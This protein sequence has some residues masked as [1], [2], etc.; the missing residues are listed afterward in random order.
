MTGRNTI[1]DERKGLL[2]RYTQLLANNEA[3]LDKK[4]QGKHKKNL[5]NGYFSTDTSSLQAELSNHRKAVLLIRF[6][7]EIFLRWDK[8]CVYN[9][10]DR[11]V[12]EKIKLYDIYDKYVIFPIELDKT[13][14][15]WF[16]AHLLYDEGMKSYDQEKYI[17]K[18]YN[19]LLEGNNYKS[20]KGFF[21]VTPEG[22]NRACIC[23][24]E[25]IRQHESFS[26][27]REM[28]EY[29]A[30][31]YGKSDLNQYGFKNAWQSIF[32]SPVA[33]LHRALPEDERNDFLFHYYEFQYW[34]SVAEKEKKAGKS[35][36]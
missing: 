5:T 12:L 13:K 35:A 15:Y 19:S 26:S 6:A 32:G 33:F 22:K 21:S 36:G 18:Y 28:Y 25:M 8:E 2:Y 27:V 9:Y 31:P 17:L 4:E 29:F 1:R 30:S 3:L 20:K 14:D 7:F 34:Y 11:Q 24:R 23:L 10:A 16:L